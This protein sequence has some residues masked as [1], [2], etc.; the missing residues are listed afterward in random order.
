MYAGAVIFVPSLTLGIPGNILSAIIWL[1]R[2]VVSNNSSA[3]YLAAIAIIDLAAQLLPLVIA[4]LSEGWLPATLMAIFQAV[5][6]L[7]GLLNL[8]F[9][10]ERL[11]AILRPFQVCCIR[12]TL[13]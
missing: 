11:I 3:V 5:A 13:W 6:N 2:H 12:L 9:S 1:R 4:F 10:T 7:E 8:G